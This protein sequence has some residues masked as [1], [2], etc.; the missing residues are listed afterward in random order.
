MG[1][2]KG[3]EKPGQ[4]TFLYITLL[5]NTFENKEYR[6]YQQDGKFSQSCISEKNLRIIRDEH[7]SM[8]FQY[9]AAAR[10]ANVIPWMY[11][12]KNIK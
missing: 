1:K 2:G 4:G 10:R 6:S 5:D 7:L 12:K 8:S 11:T 9:N 3:W